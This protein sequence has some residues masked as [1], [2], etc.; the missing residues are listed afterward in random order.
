MME[1]HRGCWIDGTA[2]PGPPYTSYWKA[3]G[4][5]IKSGRSG[6]VI[7]VGRLRDSHSATSGRYGLE[8]SR[9]AVDECLP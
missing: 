9:I 5:I 6:S 1:Q 7:E 8:L 2:V 3:L 4:T